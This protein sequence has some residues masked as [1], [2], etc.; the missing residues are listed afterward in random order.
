MSP[1][2]NLINRHSGQ[3]VSACLMEAYPSDENAFMGEAKFICLY[4]LNLDAGVGSISANT[5]SDMS[6]NA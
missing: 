1:P 2:E 6:N 3:I 4:I 5:H